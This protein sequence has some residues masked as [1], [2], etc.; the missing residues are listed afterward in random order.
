MVNYHGL[1]PTVNPH[2]TVDHSNT[3]F[4]QSWQ[5]TNHRKEDGV[6][7][8]SSPNMTTGVD[9][10]KIEVSSP[11][12]SICYGSLGQ[13]SRTLLGLSSITNH[14]VNHRT[15]PPIQEASVWKRETWCDSIHARPS[16]AS[17][18]SSSFTRVSPKPCAPRQ[19][20]LPTEDEKCNKINLLSE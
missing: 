19:V 12:L 13:I 20:P 18:T 14:Q 11:S 15:F 8:G 17:C 5:K 2:S 3:P 16:Y 9:L 6:L 10:N 7:T 4:G 1:L